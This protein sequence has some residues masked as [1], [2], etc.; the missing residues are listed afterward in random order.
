MTKRIINITSI[1][2]ILLIAISIG[3][4]I[5]K[6]KSLLAHV[7]LDKSGKVTLSVASLKPDLHSAGKGLLLEVAL[8]DKAA[9]KDLGLKVEVK[10]SKDS[11]DVLTSGLLG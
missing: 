6:A 2:L 10:D 4:G 9:V 1:L 5:A 8:H 3:I 11:L 7:D